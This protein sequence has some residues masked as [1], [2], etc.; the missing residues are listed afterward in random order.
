MKHTPMGGGQTA[1]KGANSMKTYYCVTTSFDDN[2]RVIAAIT[3]Q[4]K[5]KSKPESQYTSTRRWDIY[6]DWFGSIKEANEFVKE[7]RNETVL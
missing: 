5:A 2:G 4:M 6:S 7:A 3:D 1:R